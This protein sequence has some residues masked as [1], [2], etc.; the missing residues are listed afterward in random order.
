MFKEMTMTKLVSFLAQLGQD[1]RLSRASGEELQAA[2]ERAGLTAAERSALAN[3][4]R[5]GIEMHAGATANVC[6]F[7]F[8]TEES[9]EEGAA[10][11][12]QI[13]TAA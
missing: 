12:P 7:V 5:H 9:D 11:A 3:A 13:R 6:S 8:T 1:S 10:P 4:D 2:M